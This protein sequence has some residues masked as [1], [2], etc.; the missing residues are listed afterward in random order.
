L[1]ER[2]ENQKLSAVLDINDFII[3]DDGC[4]VV[5]E[6]L[7]ENTSFSTIEMRGNNISAT[8]FAK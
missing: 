1:K 8:G 2:L 7:R 4:R 3:G 6:F 5:S